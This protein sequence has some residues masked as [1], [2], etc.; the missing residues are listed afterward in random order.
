MWGALVGD[1]VGS[2]F[3][4]SPHKSKDFELITP[5]CRLTD[6]SILTLAVADALLHGR[7]LVD[8]LHSW[9]RAY[10]DAGYG[11]SF[12]RWALTGAREPYG[13]WGNGS[14]MRVA[15]V[16]WL[17]GDEA[18]VLA[19]ADHTAAVTHNHPEGLRGA[20][21]VALAVFWARQGRPREDMRADLQR[22]FGYDLQRRLADIAPTY[23]FDVS[24]QGSVPEALIAFFE[25]S[26]FE[27]AVRGAVALGGDS[28]TQACIAGAVAEAWFGGV[29]AVLRAEVLARCDGR[30][31][32][33]LGAFDDRVRAGAGRRDI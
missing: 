28:D 13:S 23:Q 24:C 20:R 14:A 27:D 9:W 2:R 10:P 21:A 33:V 7:D 22:H 1:M 18:E 30:Q 19:L 29:P 15:P 31:R 11:G 16:G 17:G 5:D 8:T 6:D 32:A 25:A 3:E 12:Y 26:D 4:R